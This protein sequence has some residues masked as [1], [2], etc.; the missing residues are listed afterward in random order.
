METRFSLKEKRGIGLINGKKA[1]K[2]REK[3]FRGDW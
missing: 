3:L 2:F 1:E